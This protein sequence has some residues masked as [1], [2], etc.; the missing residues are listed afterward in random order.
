MKNLLKIFMILGLAP[1]F[2]ASSAF[3]DTNIAKAAQNE[4]EKVYEECNNTIAHK[5]NNSVM[6]GNIDDVENERKIQQ[7]LRKFL[8][9]I[10]EKN[11]RAYELQKFEVAVNKAIEST[12]SIYQVLI[13]CRNDTDAIWCQDGY[14][15]DTSLGKL[16]QEKAVTSEYLKILTSLIESAKGGLDF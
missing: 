11:I 12:S 15:N 3:A 7:C 2:F 6:Q 4:A 13:F 9:K 8:F 5:Y 16:L 10:A 1:I 14:K